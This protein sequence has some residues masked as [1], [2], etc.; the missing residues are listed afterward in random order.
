MELTDFMELTKI[1]Q[2]L[3]VSKLKEKFLPP[4][5]TPIYKLSMTYMVWNISIGQ[6][7]VAAWLCSLPALAHLLLSQTRETEKSTLFFSN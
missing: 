5:P 4:Q 3:E 2:L 6:L 7:G 1:A